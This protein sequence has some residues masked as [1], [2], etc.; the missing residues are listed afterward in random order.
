M[1]S[2][3]FAVLAVA[4][5]CLAVSAGRY[6]RA[7]PGLSA[8]VPTLVCSALVWDNGVIAVGSSVGAGPLLETLSV[9][10]SWRTRC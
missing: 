7:A 1:I 4:Q 8:V 3:V 2:S 9:P 5:L 6:W 10:A